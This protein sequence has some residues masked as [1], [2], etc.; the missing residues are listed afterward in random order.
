MAEYIVRAEI[1]GTT[2]NPTITMMRLI[3]V[4]SESKS[5]SEH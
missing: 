4:N 2:A 5:I 1:A 3:G